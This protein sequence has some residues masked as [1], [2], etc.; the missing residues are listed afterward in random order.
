M[1]SKLSLK[2]QRFVDAYEGNATEAA[3]YAG[4]AHPMQQGSRLLKNVEICRAVAKRHDPATLPKKLSVEQRA[5]MLSE[6]A[7]T[8]E[9]CSDR[10]KAVDTLNKMDALYLNRVEVSNWQ[11]KSDDE[12][13]ED[14]IKTLESRG[15]TVTKN[16]N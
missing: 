13:I 2:Q 15:Y 5:E 7:K 4:Y 10:I 1:K 3:E 9:A 6:W 14:V 8:E 16:A 12:V 11:N